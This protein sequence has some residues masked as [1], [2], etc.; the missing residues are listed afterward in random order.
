[1]PIHMVNYC[2]GARRR[3]HKL[4]KLVSDPNVL[5]LAN[6]ICLNKKQLSLPVSFVFGI[7][8]IYGRKSPLF[9][10]VC[11]QTSENQHFK[12]PSFF[13]S[14]NIRSAHHS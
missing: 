3:L 6:K 7:K 11:F 1:M 5:Y 8:K 14:H 13:N 9:Q 12:I 2:I 10:T 4:G